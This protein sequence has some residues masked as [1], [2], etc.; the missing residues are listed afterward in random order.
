MTTLR[1]VPNNREV[2]K[3]QLSIAGSVVTISVQHSKHTNKSR[4]RVSSLQIVSI[5]DDK[6]RDSSTG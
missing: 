6:E 3:G 1:E 4:R 2:Q 5:V